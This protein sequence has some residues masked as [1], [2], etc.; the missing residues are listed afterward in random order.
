MDLMR[1][2][3]VEFHESGRIERDPAVRSHV[4]LGQPALDPVGIELVIPRA[5]QRVG[6]IDALAVA[7]D[8]DHLR[9]AV[10][11]LPRTRRVR[12]AA[13]H[14]AEPHRTRLDPG[15]TSGD[16]DMLYIAT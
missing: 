5:I 4:D 1:T 12:L 15:A 16:G 8:L 14:A 10:Q 7:A 6:H 3:A 13:N 9:C 11:A 2:H